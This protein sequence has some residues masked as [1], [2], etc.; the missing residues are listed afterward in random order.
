LAYRPWAQISNH[1]RPFCYTT[2][3]NDS[4]FHASLKWIH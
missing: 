1:W 2:N 4:F 3:P